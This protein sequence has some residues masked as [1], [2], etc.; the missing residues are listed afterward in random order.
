MTPAVLA[1]HRSAL[2][3]AIDCLQTTADAFRCDTDRFT[4][5]FEFADL[6]LRD[7]SNLRAA[8]EDIQHA[9]VALREML[10]DAA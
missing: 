8:V 10:D 7:R 3:T 9:M 1:Q 4:D 6:T 5:D 2:V